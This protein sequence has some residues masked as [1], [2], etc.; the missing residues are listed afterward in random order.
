MQWVMLTVFK[1]NNG[2]GSFYERLKYEIDEIDLVL[3]EEGAMDVPAPYSILSKCIDKEEK[4]RLAAIKLLNEAVAKD[5]AEEE[6]EAAANAKST[7]KATTP[8]K[9]AAAPKMR[10]V[11]P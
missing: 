10:K 8:M 2:A 5:I 7:A 11:S 1:G 6:D 9:T 3:S 4:K